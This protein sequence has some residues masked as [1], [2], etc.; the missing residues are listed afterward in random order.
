MVMSGLTLNLTTFFLGRLGPPKRLTSTKCTYFSQQ[1]TTALLK[2]EGEIMWPDWVSNP[3]PLA[4]ESDE[5]STGPCGLA[6]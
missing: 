3:G 5:L 1:L 4:L 2:S 6:T